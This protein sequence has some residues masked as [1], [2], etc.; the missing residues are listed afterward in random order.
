MFEKVSGNI[1]ILRL[2]EVNE[3]KEKRAGHSCAFLYY[4]GK[5]SFETNCVLANKL[6]RSKDKVFERNPDSYVQLY[7][8]E[9]RAILEASPEWLQHQLSKGRKP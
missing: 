9:L 2:H 7:E 4:A 3:L 8:K 5:D 6:K 1:F